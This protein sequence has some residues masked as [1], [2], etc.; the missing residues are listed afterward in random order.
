MAVLARSSP[1][2]T[3]SRIPD[4]PVVSV[5]S[6]SRVHPVVLESLYRYRRSTNNVVVSLKCLCGLWCNCVWQSRYIVTQLFLNFCIL[7]LFQ[8]PPV[9][10]YKYGVVDEETGNDFGHEESR[11]D[12]A[13]SGSYYVLLPDGRIQ[14]VIYSVNG[15]DGFVADVSYSKRR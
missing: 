10:D 11:D 3:D 4:Y 12:Q 9:Y 5:S 1:R 7:L 6:G 8:I 14:T 13:T 2:P 15:D